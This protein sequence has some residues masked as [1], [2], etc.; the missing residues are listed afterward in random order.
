MDKVVGLGNDQQSL[1]PTQNSSTM[2]MI[3]VIMVRDDHLFELNQIN[4]SSV[5]ITMMV[6]TCLL[7][8]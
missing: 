8:L 5:R 1:E 3:A 2:W 7:I 4:A 6:L